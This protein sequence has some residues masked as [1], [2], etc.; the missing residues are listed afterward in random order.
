MPSPVI[1]ACAYCGHHLEWHTHIVQSS[2]GRR[3][4]LV[5]CAYTGSRV[6]GKC[7]CNIYCNGLRPNDQEGDG[8]TCLECDRSIFDHEQVKRDLDWNL[9]TSQGHKIATTKNG[10]IYQAIPVGL[11]MC[12]RWTIYHFMRTHKEPKEI[13]PGFA[14]KCVRCKDES[15]LEVVPNHFQL[16][17]TWAWKKP[18]TKPAIITQGTESVPKP[19]VVLPFD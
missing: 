13:L 2:E 7:K 9:A 19:L 4:S 5:P 10:R 16:G 17:P 11:M 12:C 6:G 14:I 15:I 1:T 3:T 8:L 18:E